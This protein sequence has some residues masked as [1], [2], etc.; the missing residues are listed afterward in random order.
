MI[1]E[2]LQ[3]HLVCCTQSSEQLK[4]VSNKNWLFTVILMKCYIFM[5]TTCGPQL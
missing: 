2:T 3:P 4:H 5:L 1:P